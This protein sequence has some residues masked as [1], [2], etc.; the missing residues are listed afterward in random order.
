L[1]KIPFLKKGHF[2][3]TLSLLIYSDPFTKTSDPLNSDPLKIKNKFKKLRTVT[4]NHFNFRPATYLKVFL[5][6]EILSI[7]SFTVQEF[8]MSVCESY[9]VLRGRG[10][11]AKFRFRHKTGTDRNQVTQYRHSKVLITTFI[12]PVLAS[13][14]HSVPVLCRNRHFALVPVPCKNCMKV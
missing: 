5:F 7:F 4:Q 9:T 14:F 13:P 3:L 2:F 1:P 8:Y 11:W 12:M 10:T 6:Q